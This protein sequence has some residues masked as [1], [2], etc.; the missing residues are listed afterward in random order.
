MALWGADKSRKGQKLSSY[1]TLMA[2]YRNRMGMDR[3]SRSS[4]LS[5]M[6]EN[7]SVEPCSCASCMLMRLSNMPRM[8]SIH[9]WNYSAC[10]SVCCE[11]IV[12]M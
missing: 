4:S 10:L 1:A 3:E 8:G 12:G 9:A 2:E 6:A 7:P 11:M 5:K